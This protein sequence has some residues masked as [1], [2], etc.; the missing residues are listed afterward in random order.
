MFF[1]TIMIN[2]D[3]QTKSL[4]YREKLFDKYYKMFITKYLNNYY[5][6]CIE[7]LGLDNINKIISELEFIKTLNAKGYVHQREVYNVLIPIN[8]YHRLKTNNEI[9]SIL[10][11]DVDEEGIIKG[12]LIHNKFDF[13]SDNVLTNKYLY[14]SDLTVNI[15][16]IIDTLSTGLANN[17]TMDDINK[18]MLPYDEVK[19][20][21]MNTNISNIINNVDKAR[22]SE[23][24]DKMSN[25]FDNYCEKLYYDY[26]HCSKFRTPPMIEHF[27][28]LFDKYIDAW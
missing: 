2:D 3:L 6:V 17:F 8:T 28:G 24:S 10:T 25:Y 11:L 1:E 18:H 7:S 16:S 26:I 22:I 4:T 13:L 9:P 15:K 19:K 27:K 14:T 12:F 20:Q 5:K 23:I 21:T